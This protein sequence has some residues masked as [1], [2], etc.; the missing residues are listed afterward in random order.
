MKIR[1]N[2]ET[3]L[4]EM[5]AHQEQDAVRRRAE[6]EESLAYRSTAESTQREA[7]AAAA[8]KAQQQAERRQE[9]DAV[10]RQQLSYRRARAAEDRELDQTIAQKAAEELRQQQED[11]LVGR[12]ARMRRTGMSQSL[13]SSQFSRTQA[14]NLEADEYIQRA[15][16]EVNAKEDERR[17]RDMAARRRLM[18]DAVSDRVQTMKIHE[19]QKEQRKEQKE[20]ERQELEED[21]A[22]KRQLDE[23]ERETRRRLVAN[24]SQMLA[25]QCRL[26]NELQNR[27]KQEDRDSVNALIQGWRDEED[28]IRDELAHPHALVGGRF[29]GHR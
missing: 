23:E 29:R 14:S 11:E 27:A 16:D 18:L 10:N 20:V 9:L 26:K 24:Q 3:W 6:Y 19:M 4:A 28:R 2:R 8:E 25:S 7:Q 1:Q 12:L 21:L 13:L 5:R 17:A 22:L 15:Q